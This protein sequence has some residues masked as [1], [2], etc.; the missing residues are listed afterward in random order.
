MSYCEC[1]EGIERC[2][3]WADDTEDSPTL[4][5]LCEDCADRAVYGEGCIH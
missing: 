1:N 5:G 2:W 3:N 4:V